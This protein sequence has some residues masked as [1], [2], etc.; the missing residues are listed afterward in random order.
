MRKLKNIILLGLL[1][2]AILLLVTLVDC[3]GD[4]PRLEQSMFQLYLVEGF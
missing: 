1:A 3:S 4:R 2:L